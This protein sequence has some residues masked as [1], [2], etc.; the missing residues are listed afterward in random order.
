M[1]RIIERTV[2]GMNRLGMLAAE[3]ALVA[4]VLITVYAVVARYVF[5]SPSANSMEVSVYLLLVATWGAVGWVHHAD[6][7][8]CMEAV[9]ARLT[10]CW[11][12]ASRVISQLS[13][14]AFCA[15]LV[16]AGYASALEKLEKNY[17]STSLL[18]FPL[19]MPYALIPIGGLLL[20]AMAVL[21]LMRAGREG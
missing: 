10:G 1:S 20:V 15:M 2:M 3:A 13:V 16:W 12:V 9:S 17:R 7:H 19:W 14:L 11:K 5:N 4:L 6:R 8:V 21:R 18:E